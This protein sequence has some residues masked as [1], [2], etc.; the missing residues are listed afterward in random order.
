MTLAR[1]LLRA[2]TAATDPYFANV[3]MLLHC[4][5]ADAGVTFTDA[6]S[7]GRAITTVG[8]A[9]I[10]TAQS[11][12]GGASALF[13]GVGD[14]LF[15]AASS[16][17]NIFGSDFTVEC[18][19]RFNS[20]ANAPHFLCFGSGQTNRIALYLTGNTIRLHVQVAGSGGDRITTSS[21][22]TGVWYHVALTKVSG[23][24]TLWLNGVSQGTS[25]ATYPA[26]NLRANIGWEYF[27]GAGGDYLN[28]WLDEIRVTQGVAR[29]TS[30][31][32]P[33]AAPF[34]DA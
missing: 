3:V 11:K 31:F 33:P 23:T 25:T 12:F 14:Y 19:V 7:Y 27:Y 16:D 13:D 20:L 10:D 5:G 28:G 17:F 4:D 24:Y 21:V 6:S 32:T 34:P 29:Y 8:N 1:K 30:A 18:F 9:Q 26:G 2:N 22:T 15:A